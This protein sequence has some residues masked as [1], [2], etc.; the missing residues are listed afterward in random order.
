MNSYANVLLDK[1]G[2]SGL[3]DI[4]SIEEMKIVKGKHAS[5]DNN[6]NNI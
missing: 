2:G 6:N 1:I 3:E 5:R 4:L